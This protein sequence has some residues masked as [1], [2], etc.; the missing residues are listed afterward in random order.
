MKF[1]LG[2]MSVGDIFDRG[3][4]LLLTRLGT[5]FLIRAY[6]NTVIGSCVANESAS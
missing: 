5:F 1:Q 4:K 3:L 6:P 2:A